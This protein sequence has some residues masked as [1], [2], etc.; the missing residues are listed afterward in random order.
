M[1]TFL[2]SETVRQF[3]LILQDFAISSWKIDFTKKG[4]SRLTHCVLMSSAGILR[5]QLGSRPGPTKCCTWSGSQLFDTLMLFLKEIFK[6]VDFKIKFSR[7]KK[8]CKITRLT[9]YWSF[10]SFG[11]L[12][13]FTVFL[14]TPWIIVLLKLFACWE[15]FHQFLSSADFFK[16]NFFKKFFHENHQCQT[17]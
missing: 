2:L 4:Y 5:K 13:H 12:A 6:K 9:T 7:H 16:I 11:G 10:I 15:I 1:D 8:A 3:C 14:L 17:V